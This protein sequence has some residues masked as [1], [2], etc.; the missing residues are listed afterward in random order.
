MKKQWIVTVPD[1]IAHKYD[2]K[3]VDGCH[4]TPKYDCDGKAVYDSYHGRPGKRKCE[5]KA[6]YFSR[7]RLQDMRKCMGKRESIGVI[8]DSKT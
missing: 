3:V 8:T 2:E 6:V 5:E 1:F 7:R 4:Q